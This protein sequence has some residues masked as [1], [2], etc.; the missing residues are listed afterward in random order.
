MT[1]STWG[2]GEGE[3]Q[4]EVAFNGIKDGVPRWIH[5][6]VSRESARNNLTPSDQLII[7][8]A[9][10]RELACLWATCSAC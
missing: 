4:D 9:A 2:G 8:R 6:I 3:R 1:H 7:W 5:D 10:G